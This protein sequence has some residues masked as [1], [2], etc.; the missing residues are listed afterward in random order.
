MK[1]ERQGTVQDRRKLMFLSE[2]YTNQYVNKSLLMIY[3]SGSM[4]FVARLVYTPLEGPGSN[5]NNICS[6]ATATFSMRQDTRIAPPLSSDKRRLVIC[7]LQVNL[8]FPN[9]G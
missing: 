9:W 3:R 7:N 5:S 6:Q 8:F 1:L 4:H 2:L